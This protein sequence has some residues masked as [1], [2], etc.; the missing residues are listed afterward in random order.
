M[1]RAM[2]GL[3]DERTH[4][5]GRDRATRRSPPRRDRSVST[6][7][8]GPSRCDRSAAPSPSPRRPRGLSRASTV[9]GSITIRLP[10]G[11]RP[12]VRSSGR[13]KVRSSFEPG[14]DVRRRHRQRERHRPARPGLMAAPTRTTVEGGR[15]HDRV[16][17]H[18]RLHRVHRHTRRRRGA[19]AAGDAG[20]SRAGQRSPTGRASSRSSA[21]G[22]CSG[23][24]IRSAPCTAR[25]RSTAASK[26]SRRRPG[27]RC[28]SG[29]GCTTAR[30]SSVA[31]TS[32]ATT[33]TSRRGSSTSPLPARCS[34]P[35]PCEPEW[36]PSAAH[37]CFAELGPVVMKGIPEPIRLWRATP[38]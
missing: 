30:P 9:S 29:S 19:A 37:V 36:I 15:G 17:R 11:V 22:C 3:D 8:R 10:A 12:T 21:T 26:R 27:S 7:R 2:P 16:H 14:D 31:P 35:T 32:S 23:S 34:S 20:P 4:H 5:G 24:P 13:G 33:S 1:R 25:S 6:A 28:G 38:N 18:R